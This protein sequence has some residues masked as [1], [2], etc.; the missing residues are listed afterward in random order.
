MQFLFEHEKQFVP[1]K[2]IAQ[3]ADVSDKTIRKYIKTLN[4]LLKDFG[5]SIEMKL[6]KRPLKIQFSKCYYWPWTLCVE[7]FLSE[8]QWVK[9][10]KEINGFDINPN[11]SEIYLDDKLTYI[12]CIQ[13]LLVVES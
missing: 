9:Q 2:E 1:S 4:N 7:C 11:M 12:A 6:I 13:E 3:K 5:A 10:G 8:N